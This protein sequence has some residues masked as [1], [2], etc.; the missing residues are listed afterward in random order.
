MKKEEVLSLRD[1]VSTT[2]RDLIYVAADVEKELIIICFFGR[3]IELPVEEVYLR[4]NSCKGF[5]TY[6]KGKITEVLK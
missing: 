1:L 2:V 6:L 5:I 4:G 3:N